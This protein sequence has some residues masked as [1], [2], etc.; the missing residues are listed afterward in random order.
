MIQTALSEDSPI[1]ID[2]HDDE[3]GKGDDWMPK[4]LKW[5]LNASFIGAQNVMIGLYDRESNQLMR[6][7]N[8]PTSVVERRCSLLWHIDAC[9]SFLCAVL[10]KIKVVC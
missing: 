2:V 10:L 9:F 6:V 4:S 3:L 8:I 7:V 1:Y 5:C